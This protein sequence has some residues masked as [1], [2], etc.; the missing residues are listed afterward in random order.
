VQIV[1][2][3]KAAAA[4]APAGVAVDQ[5]VDFKA[6]QIQVTVQSTRPFNPALVAQST[7]IAAASVLRD[8]N[9]QFTTSGPAPSPGDGLI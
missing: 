1:E 7:G 5:K 8:L 2:R 3:K 9:V 4:A 6:Q